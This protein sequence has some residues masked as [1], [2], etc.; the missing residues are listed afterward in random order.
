VR[1]IGK[2]RAA[3]CTIDKPHINK[4]P[5]GIPVSVNSDAR[6]SAT[7][8]SMRENYPEVLAR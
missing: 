1:I 4:S 7:L 5:A 6:N 8:A 2:I 3:A